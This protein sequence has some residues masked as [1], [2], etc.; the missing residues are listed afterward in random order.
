M[1]PVAQDEEQTR[2]KVTDILQTLTAE[3]HPGAAARRIRPHD[4]L[5][6]D[7]GIGSVERLELVCRLEQ[8]LGHRVSDR[9]VLDARTVE[10]LARAAAGGEV[11]VARPAGSPGH[12]P[13]HGGTVQ[14]TTLFEVVAGQ[15][16]RQGGRRFVTF[17]R[18]GEPYHTYTFSELHEKSQHVAAGLA[19]LGVHRGDRV[20]IM[21]GTSPEF[22]L[23]FFGAVSLGAVPVPLYPPMRPNPPAEFIRRQGRIIDNAGAGV[24]ITVEAIE[25]ASGILRPFARSLRHVVTVDRITSRDRLPPTPVEADATA[26]LQ[27]TSGSTGSPRGVDLTHAA[28]LSNLR[29]FGAALDIRPSDVVVS[30]LPLYHDMGLIGMAMGAL[31][32]GLPLVLMG[33]EEFLGRPSRWLWA[34]HGYKGSITAAP[35]FGYE[36]CARKISDEDAKGLDL[37]HW[38]VAI[39]GA[40][41]VR[42]ATLRA[43]EERYAA[44][45]FPRGAFMPAFGLAE[46]TL[47]ITIAPPGRELV[48]RPHSSGA[49]VG[50]GRPVEGVQVRIADDVNGEGRVQFRST[51]AMRGYWGEERAT[52]AMRTPDGWWDTGDLGF[53]EGSELFITGRS[54]D[55][56]VKGGHNLHAEDIEQAANDTPGVRRGCA[57]AFGVSDE[58]QGTEKVVVIVEMRPSPDE[59]QQAAADEVRRRV[60]DSCG[61]MPDEVLVMPPGTVPKTP[62]GKIRRSACRDRYLRGTLRRPEGRLPLLRDAVTFYAKQALPWTFRMA[63]AAWC[64]GLLASYIGLIVG[65]SKVSQKGAQAFAHGA[66]RG[67][68]RLNGFRLRV[69]GRLPAR[70]TFLVVANHGSTMD[71]IVLT[72]AMNRSARF[73]AA[74]WVA[75]HPLLGRLVR[76]LRGIVVQRGNPHAAADSIKDM[77]AALEAGECVGVFAEGGLEATPG[78]RPFVLGPFQAAVQAGVPVIPVGLRGTRE[79]LRWGEVMPTPGVLEVSIGEPLAPAGQAW[80]DV[81]DLARRTRAAIAERCGEPLVEQRLLRRD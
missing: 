73:A 67:L 39:N 20:A 14:A 13:G 44:H 1:K 41:P 30:W 32:Y 11:A 79:G 33:P 42:P 36:M 49:L 50:C 63:R 81:V 3:L 54:K 27:Y 5:E 47:A 26:F 60:F 24:L 71:P 68:L 23:A 28:L 52:A 9:A 12:E 65:I 48:I 43:F 31:Y 61:V 53:M 18:Q 70:G 17:L 59:A 38:R 46:A 40:E 4:E 22:F 74:P 25:R 75:A 58:R 15:A 8:S 51:A 34:F 45:G 76:A 80:G 21:L 78:L 2:E 77:R 35:N 19:D 29:A 69:H 10:E 7:L 56:I 37:S 55:V 64:G 6:A 57:A 72:A 16:A 66:G 62:S